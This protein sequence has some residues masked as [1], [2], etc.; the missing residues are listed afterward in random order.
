MGFLARENQIPPASG[1]I[2]S[3]MHYPMSQLTPCEM[4]PLTSP[5]HSNLLLPNNWQDRPFSAGNTEAIQ[6]HF[7]GHLWLAYCALGKGVGIGQK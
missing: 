5:S 7:K 3:Q 6:S 1:K 2:I 4:T